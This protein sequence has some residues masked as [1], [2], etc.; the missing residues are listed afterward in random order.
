[1]PTTPDTFYRHD[2]LQGHVH[3]LDLRAKECMQLKR[4][5]LCARS[6]KLNGKVAWELE[7]RAVHGRQR[8]LAPRN[9]VRTR[10]MTRDRALVLTD[11]KGTDTGPESFHADDATAKL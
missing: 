4:A 8:S 9:N 3:W 10:Q 6:V 11:G 2:G 7:A 5:L 1:M